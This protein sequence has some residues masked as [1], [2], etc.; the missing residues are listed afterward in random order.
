MRVHVLGI[1]GTFMG[2]V[3]LLARALGHQ[4]SGCDAGVYPP[5]SEQLAAAGI[6]LTEGYEPADQPDADAYVIGNALSRGNAFVEHLLDADAPYTS[7]PAWLAGHVLAGR[8]VLAVAGTHGKTTTASLAAYLLEA[9]GH[10]PGFLIG[11]VPR[12]FGVSARLGT[13]PFVV[14]ADEYDTA[15]FDK[16]AKFVHYRPR[17]ALLNNLEHDHADIYPDLAAIEWQ[18]HQLVRTVPR[19]GTLVVKAGDAALGRVLARGCWTPRV[20]FGA[21]GA[22]QAHPE[23]PDGRTFRV[24]RD[25]HEVGVARWNLLGAHNVD[26]AL[27]ALAAVAALGVEPAE[28]VAALGGFSG[29]RR[30]LEVIAQGRGAV[31]YDDFAHHPTAIA[32]TLA[33]VRAAHPQDRLV[34]VVDLRS[35]SMRLGAHRATLAGALAG[36]DV[37]HLHSATPLP[38]DIREVL[39]A[40]PMPAHWH[41]TTAPLGE[42]LLAD[43]RPGDQVVLMSNGA[44]GDLHA[45]LRQALAGTPGVA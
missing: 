35:N 22:W 21:G 30:R 5:M 34:A 36:A 6:P 1:C 28:A 13:G 45:R 4:V 29:V 41:G 9:S 14:E 27:A 39:D 32:T 10:D 40:L 3:A 7:G 2:G 33:G 17:V 44:F 16:R 15:F 18:F 25:G 38:W 12:D 23:S 37:V 26:N 8:T 42:A 19:A 43:L 11:G 24:Y 31:V 20:A